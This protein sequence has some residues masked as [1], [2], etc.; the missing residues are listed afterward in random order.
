MLLTSLTLAGFFHVETCVEK[1]GWM[2]C[3]DSQECIAISEKESSSE[4]I[5]TED[6]K[7]RKKMKKIDITIIFWYINEM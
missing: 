5:L 3:S 7:V 4:D 1:S 2:D 6:F